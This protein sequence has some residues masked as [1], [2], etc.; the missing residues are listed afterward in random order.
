M[1]DVSYYSHIL[2]NRLTF[3]PPNINKKC[4][5]LNEYEEPRTL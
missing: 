4:I 2:D 3:S 5:G 1:N